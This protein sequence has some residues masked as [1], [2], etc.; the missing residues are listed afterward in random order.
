MIFKDLNI[1]DLQ[2]KIIQFAIIYDLQFKIV[3]F[4]I[5]YDLQ[6]KIVRFAII[7]DLR[8]WAA[9]ETR[10]RDPDLGKVVLYQLSYCRNL[11]EIARYRAASLHHQV[12]LFCVR[13]APAL[14]QVGGDGFEPPKVTTSR[15][16]VCPIWPLWYP[17][18]QYVKDVTPAGFKPTTFWSVV[19]CSIQL[20][21]GA[22]LLC[23]PRDFWFCVAH[24]R[25]FLLE[26]GCKGSAFFWNRQMF[27]QLFFI[28]W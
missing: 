13:L 4:A 16:T 17:P 5:I 8:Y 21:Y 24:L 10:T 11:F 25:R 2:F 12:N 18:R 22:I 3:R 28:L 9:N 27:L 6:F 23:L 20:S 14:P 7:Y 26:S 1:Y 15:F 19:R